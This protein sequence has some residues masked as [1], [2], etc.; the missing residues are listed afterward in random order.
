MSSTVLTP[1]LTR[2][3]FVK[4]G[5]AGSAALVIGFY[6]PSLAATQQEG[7]PSKEAPRINPLN[8]WIRIGADGNV[9][10][11]VGKSE[12]GQGVMTSLPMILADEVEVDWNSVHVEQAATKPDIYSLGTGGSGSVLDSYLPLRQAGA[13]ARQMLIQ[14]AADTWGVDPASCFAKGGAVIHN[15]RGHRL[16]YGEL[17]AKASKLPVP[18]LKTVVLKNPDNF[19]YIGTSLP[20]LDIPSKVDGSAKFG[21]DVR[22]PGMLYA[23]VARC[24]VFGGKLKSFDAAK[25]KAVPGVREVVEIPPVEK[26]AH[27]AGGIAVVADSTWAAIQGRDALVSAWDNGPH[28]DESTDSLREQLQSLT[29]KPGKIVRKEGDVEAALAAAANKIEASYELPFLAHAT[30]EPMNCTA[31]VRSNRAEIWAPT[32]GPDWNQSMV[33]QVLKLPPKSV[34][35]HTVLM[36]GGFGR[37]YQTDFAVEAAQVSKAIGKPVQ[38]LWTRED[39]MQHDFYRPASHHRMAAALDDK[40]GIAAWRH[41][42]SS[43]SIAE[44][45]RSSPNLAEQEIGSAEVLPYATA[46][47]QIEY[48]AA[49]SGVPRAWW[50]SVEQTPSA[51]AV[52]SFIDELAAAAKIDPYEYRLRLFD[53]RKP[54]SSKLWP[55]GPPLNVKRMKA[56]LKLAAEKASWGTPAPEGRSRGIACFYSFNTYAAEVAEVSVV[57]GGKF[58]VHRVTCAVDCGRAVEPDGV[59]AQVEGGIVYALSAVLTGE[60]TIANGSVVQ[61][62]FNDYKVMRMRDMPEVEVHIVPSTERPTGVGEP[63]LPPLAPAV[64][65]AIFAATGKRIRR[66]PIRAADLA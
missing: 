26:G 41:R 9:T 63:G 33:A 36:G 1:K 8:A 42:V 56:T 15:P 19:R 6:L 51:F 11:I 37:R 59:K 61:S 57:A 7:G 13:A 66:L 52:E 16:A 20:R 53:E 23:V 54:M 40:G 17:A 14:A 3:G 28:A 30:M 4:V 29:A 44:F 62:N 48:S 64:T 58:R 38:L 45:W 2:R 55:E 10:L 46:N 47:F 12:M 65:S 34:V 24:L 60:I 5:A 50:R 18:D 25:A 32:Q 27:T 31:D 35:V 49:K 39:D 22:V 43:T 21:I